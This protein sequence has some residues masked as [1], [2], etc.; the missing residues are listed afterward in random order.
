MQSHPEQNSDPLVQ[1]LLQIVATT[2][3]QEAIHLLIEKSVQ[4]KHSGENAEHLTRSLVNTVS[5][6][7]LVFDKDWRLRLFNAAA[8]TLFQLS[9]SAVGSTL[10]EVVGA[11]ELAAFAQGGQALGEW[12]PDGTNPTVTEFTAFVPRVYPI[13]N[14]DAS[15]DGW[16]LA[17]RDISQF[18]KLN[19]NQSEFVRIVS[20]DLRSP[21][22]SMQ[23]FA[24]MLEL[25]LVGELNEKQAQF[26]EKILAGIAQITALVDNIQDAGRFDPETGFYEMERSPCD[27][28][29]I[30]VR[31]VQNHLVP[32]EKQEL[33]IS[34]NVADDVPIINADANMLERAI[35]NLVDNAIKYTP[36]GGKVDVNVSC[37]NNDLHISVRDTGLGI[38]P[39]HQ[40]QLFQRHV[41][42]ARQEHKR[43]KGTGLG[44][45]IV[46][47]V[48]QRHE[49]NAWVNSSD[50]EGSTFTMSIP[51]DGANLIL[52]TSS[53]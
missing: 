32:A 25:E 50:G 26:V 51:L 36:N 21:L 30:V 46:K 6:P 11:D 22:T 34:V 52:P 1:E 4:F 16:V 38:N 10:G 29:E 41:R 31:I 24:S 19:R 8:A 42:I 15:A 28:G 9:D 23:G 17:L 18:K 12:T 14:A 13:Q 43:I 7:L 40:Q 37:V 47:S 44:L 3:A 27:V 20:H 2:P 39:E 5:D 33:S 48:A 35:T 53:N 49:G 45:F